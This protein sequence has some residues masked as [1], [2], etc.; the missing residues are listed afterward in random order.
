MPKIENLIVS[1]LKMFG[2]GLTLAELSE[3]MGESEKKTFKGLRKLF[4]EGTISCQNRRYSL[5]LPEP[6][7]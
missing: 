6:E 4:D 3:K 7:S 1:T 2:T 5:R